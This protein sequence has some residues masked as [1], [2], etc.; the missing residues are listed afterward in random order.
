MKE[1]FRTG[2]LAIPRRYGAGWLVVDRSRWD[3]M[4]DLP[5]VE[6]DGRFTLY[7]LQSSG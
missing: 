7:R 6:R 2:D 4:P 1:F 3:L 5:V